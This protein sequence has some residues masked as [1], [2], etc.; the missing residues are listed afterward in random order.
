MAPPEYDLLRR[1]CVQVV[2]GPSIYEVVL[3]ICLSLK[4]PFF[5]PFPAS[6]KLN[7]QKKHE[8]STIIYIR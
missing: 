2:A 7:H 3:L 6:T 4:I 1:V 5:F 8:M